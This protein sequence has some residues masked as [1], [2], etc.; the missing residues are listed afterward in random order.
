M[1]Q[2]ILAVEFKVVKELYNGTSRQARCTNS[3]EVNIVVHQT[4]DSQWQALESSFLE[5]DKRQKRQIYMGA[6]SGNW[7]EAS[8]YF[9][10]H[11][12]W[13]RIPLSAV[14]TTA[15]HVAVS[16][17]QTSFIEKLMYCMNM[18]DLE[19]YKV[20]GNTA[21]CLA[22]ITGNLKIVE[23]LFRKNARLLW[24]RDKNH[25]LPIQLASS[26]GHNQLTEF[27]YLKTTEDLQTKLSFPDIVKLF[28]L[29]MNNNIYSVASKLLD[30][31]SKLVTVENEEGLTPLQMLAQ[32]SLCEGNIAHQ[33]IVCSVF[34]GMERE[35]ETINH[36]QVSK[37]MFDAAESG[38]IRILKRLFKYHPDLLF[39]VNSSKQSLLHVAILHRQQSVY[40][41]ILSKGAAKSVLIQ[42]ADIEDN[43][44][45]HLAA[46]MTQPKEKSG[47]TAYYVLMRSEER[48]F[49]QIVEKIVPPAMKT[50]RNI[51]GKT[52]GEVFYESHEELHKESISGLLAVT[53]TLLVVATLIVSLGI[54]GAMTIPIENIDGTNTPFFTRK[55]WYTFFFLSV[56]FGTCFCVSSMF[57]YAS[58][59]LPS[60]WA[61]P[62][63]ES[64]RLRQTKL[65]FGNVALFCSLGLM[66]TALISA[67]VL[68]FE[69]LSSWIL[70][71]TCGLGLV[72][73][74]VHLTL[75]YKRWIGI[76]SSV[77]S[78]LEDSP[79]KRAKLIWPIYKIYR[80]FLILTKKK[81]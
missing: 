80:V 34:N 52:P 32:S 29:T 28:F 42:L 3:G 70:Y 20:E 74:I 31:E 44:V 9:K 79:G 81:A 10:I 47:L 56:A 61:K 15:L 2:E 49:Q 22:A 53:N 40:R 18:E 12:Y 46:K 6:A 4:Q 38:N 51:Y 5:L 78:Y 37:A 45:L 43:T 16:M 48:W 24:I 26:A 57:F 58:V 62:K 13:W 66:F 71:F 59:I 54:T 21:F 25:M 63:E 67:S 8:S 72:V 36:A 68:I 14:G 17:E 33:G 50:M 55:I 41:L 77:L 19:N 1:T 35:Q 60:S 23:I 75:D 30:S 39:E 7:N 27:L 69:F 64:V 11:P 65:V 73:L 76:I